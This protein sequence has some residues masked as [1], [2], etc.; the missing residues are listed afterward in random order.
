LNL[1]ERQLVERLRLASIRH[2]PI[3]AGAYRLRQGIGDDCAVIS[4]APLRDRKQKSPG[5]DLLVTTDLFLEDI[6]F[7][8]AWQSADSV[9]HKVLV[10]GLSDIAAMGGEPRYAFLSLGLPRRIDSRWVNDFFRGF[11][12]LAEATGVTL[13]G[14]DTGASRSG[15]VADIMVI[16]EV[17][18]GKAVLRSGARPGDEIWVTGYLGGAAHALGLLRR[19]ARLAPR[20]AALK[21]LFYPAP[22]LTIGR[23]LRE[24]SLASAMMDLS[25]G[26]SIDLARL[27]RSSNVGACVEEPLLPRKSGILARQALHG[28]EDFELLFTVRAK[29]SRRVPGEIGGVRLTRIGRITRG[30]QLRLLQKGREVPLPIL[31]FEHF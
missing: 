10:R 15:I 11:F 31:G 13:A 3:S 21:P 22:R 7:R 12:G 4:S 25:D 2:R 30:S 24:Q 5:T 9:G 8:R 26:L 17:P 28:G 16:G 14:G 19:G 6:H 20:S 27:C 1:S 29:H 23:A 18:S